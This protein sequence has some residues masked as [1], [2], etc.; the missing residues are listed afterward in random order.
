MKF[1]RYKTSAPGTA[2]TF[3]RD[4]HLQQWEP[5]EVVD[6]WEPQINF[7]FRQW[8]FKISVNVPPHSLLAVCMGNSAKLKNGFLT[9]EQTFHH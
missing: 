9:H 1:K 7:Y 3:Q 4:C 8:M 5:Y 6:H 2:S